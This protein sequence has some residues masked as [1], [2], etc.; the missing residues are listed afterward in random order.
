MPVP[1]IDENAIHL[2]SPAGPVRDPG[3]GEHGLHTVVDRMHLDGRH[4]LVGHIDQAHGR[5]DPR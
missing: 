1:P 2:P 3:H 5:G 4:S